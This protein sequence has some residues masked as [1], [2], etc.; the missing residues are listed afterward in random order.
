MKKDN[1]SS[2]T[3]IFTD[4]SSRGNPGPGGWGALIVEEGAQARVRELGGG[5][6]DTT[7]NR[8][9]IMAAIGGLKHSPKDSEAIINTD[10][11]YLINGIT[12]WVKGWKR[13][14]WKTKTKDDVLNRDLWEELHE[15]AEGR[16]IKWNYVGGHVGI[17]GNERCDHIAT[18][19][20]DGMKIDLYDGPLSGYDLP[21]IL[22]V[23]HDEMKA[24][25]KK[26]SSSKS[27]APAY[28][29]VSSVGGVIET[30]RTWPECE[31]RVKGAKGARY[32]KAVSKEDETNIIA[33][34]ADF[35]SDVG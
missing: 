1:A 17:L 3:T 6:N 23:S 10:S 21:N 35:G 32:K 9:E 33:S 12:K 15:L 4:G 31:K 29:Y 19:F 8:M 2:R 25:A 18:A 28:S 24:V 5:E 14:G 22:D 20:A 16:M 34:F 27:K 11:S 7:N 26:S 13:N 30:H